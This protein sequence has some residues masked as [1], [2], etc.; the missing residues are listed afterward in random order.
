MYEPD[1]VYGDY[2]EIDLKTGDWSPKKGGLGAKKDEIV[3]MT[4][5]GDG[6]G[7]REGNWYYDLNNGKYSETRA[8]RETR[9]NI[10]SACESYLVSKYNFVTWGARQSVSLKSYRVQEGTSNYVQLIGFGGIRERKLLKNDEEWNAWVK[11]NIQSDSFL[12]YNK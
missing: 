8:L 1:P 6:S 12:D 4:L 11:Q 2:L 5:G 10:L 3:G 9:L 7:K